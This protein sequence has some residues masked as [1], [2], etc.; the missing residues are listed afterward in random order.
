MTLLIVVGLWPEFENRLFDPHHEVDRLDA[1]K[2]P[3]E[4]RTPYSGSKDAV[5][6]A[7][8]EAAS[9]PVD[10]MKTME[11]REIRYH[12]CLPYCVTT[13]KVSIVGMKPLVA[14]VKRSPASSSSGDAI[15]RM[16]GKSLAVKTKAAICMA[17]AK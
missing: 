6:H 9:I 11:D 8:E 16:S 13:A 5:Y 1:T 15:H 3:H 14:R 17:P 4:A 7:L 12:D 10:K 2:S